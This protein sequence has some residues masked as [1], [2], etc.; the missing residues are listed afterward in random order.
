MAS[1]PNKKKNLNYLKE[2]FS[3]LYYT[4]HM[5]GCP[6]SEIDDRTRHCLTLSAGCLS[7]ASS[8]YRKS[9]GLGTTSRDVKNMKRV[10]QC[11][12]IP[13][14]PP[15]YPSPLIS[16]KYSKRSKK[17]NMKSYLW[18]VIANIASSLRGVVHSWINP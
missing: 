14:I 17:R 4:P 10:S 9:L 3:N 6:D 8:N 16:S 12:I 11:L 1:G 15:P 18:N 7:S 5:V 13:S 2:Q